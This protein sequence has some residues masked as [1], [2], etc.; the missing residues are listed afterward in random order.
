M[1]NK[2]LSTFLKMSGFS[3]FVMVFKPKKRGGLVPAKNEEKIGLADK[4][5]LKFFELNE[6]YLNVWVLCD[7]V[8]TD[9]EVC[10]EFADYLLSNAPKSKKKVDKNKLV[11]EAKEII[12]KLLKFNLLE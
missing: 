5:K 6:A 12:K 4:E 1:F 9:D 8:K 11:L 3:L 7:G 2:S 10:G